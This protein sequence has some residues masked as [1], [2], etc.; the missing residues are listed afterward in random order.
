[1][2]TEI[3]ELN[4]RRFKVVCNQI[5]EQGTVVIQKTFTCRYL[6]LAAGSIGTTELLLRAK[7]KGKL[8]RLNDNVGMNWGTNGDSIGIVATKSGQTNPTQGGPAV[9]GIEDFDNPIAPVVIEQIPFS[10]LPEGVYAT[11][12]QGITLP[13]GKLTYNPKTNSTDLF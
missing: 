8:R 11:L 3:E 13:E 7:Y 9:G 2:V 12:G 5:N 6:F 10:S 1:M 4:Q